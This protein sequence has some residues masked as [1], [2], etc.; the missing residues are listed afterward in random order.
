[1]ICIL[2]ERGAKGVRFHLEGGG[3]SPPFSFIFHH[4]PSEFDK[5]EK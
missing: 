2:E 5:S 3:F 1:M 4:F